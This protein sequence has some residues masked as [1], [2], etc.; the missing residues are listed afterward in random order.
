MSGRETVFLKLDKKTSKRISTSYLEKQLDAAKAINESGGRSYIEEYSTRIDSK[1]PDVMKLSLPRRKR[2][3]GFLP[4][5][6]ELGF[7]KDEFEVAYLIEAL[8]QENIK[9]GNVAH[10]LASHSGSVRGF[11]SGVND[12]FPDANTNL[13]SI[14]HIL[15]AHR[16][17][18]LAA[19]L[20]SITDALSE[21]LLDADIGKS[22]EC[23]F[24][25]CPHPMQY[26]EFGETPCDDVLIYN[27]VSG[28]HELEGMY[29]NEYVL[30][31]EGMN[32]EIDN[33]NVDLHSKEKNNKHNMI[34]YAI[35]SGA[36]KKDGGD[37][38]IIEI[39]ATGTPLNKSG[40]FDDATL[41]FTIIYQDETMSVMELINW[42]KKYYRGELECQT[43]EE[44]DDVYD[45]LS[46]TRQSTITANDEKSMGEIIEVLAKSL[47]YINSENS[48]KEEVND[49]K[50]ADIAIKRTLNKAK[51]RKLEKRTKV[52]M[53]YIRIGPVTTSTNTAS[54]PD[55]NNKR[56]ATHWRR[57]HFRQQAHGKGR[58]LRK[59]KWIARQ[60][61]N[62]T[63]ITGLSGKDYKVT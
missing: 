42:H 17:E 45:G 14:D 12:T 43:N 10:S 2:W 34:S 24:L 8:S 13:A 41:S 54:V 46:V 40:N 49:R 9:I 6:F 33:G 62:S 26:I 35:E 3:L 25:K 59:V 28:W 1:N 4:L 32:T 55:S 30:T 39:L 63:N 51:K 60:I 56:K 22:T 36:V 52:A 58:S 29:V 50:A 38:R 15:Y 16:F 47:L 19:P 48:I 7:I 23:Y 11:I 57:A 18:M 20:F 53:D 31:N 27:N 37:V 44:E 5:N 21:Q 61:V